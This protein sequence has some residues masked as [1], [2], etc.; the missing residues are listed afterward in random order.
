M[1]AWQGKV[2][3]GGWP[4]ADML[5]LGH[6]GIRAERGVD[7]ASLLTHDEQYTLMS[8]WAIFRSPL[9]FGGD[10][11][12]SDA[13]T[14]SLLTNTEV[15][16]VNQRSDNGR[17]VYREADTISWLADIPRS[18]AK[19][20]TVSNIGDTEKDV[21]LPWKTFG[22][23][24]KSYSIRDLWMHKE[25]GSRDAFSMPLKPHASVLLKVTEH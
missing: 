1:E 20:L 5:P 15:L 24:A 19:Y 18:T 2:H 17:E 10:I 6:I 12:S 16:A 3:R 25:L 13:F 14:I 22:L 7:R 21:H 23:N 11:P 4:D 8:M 9:M